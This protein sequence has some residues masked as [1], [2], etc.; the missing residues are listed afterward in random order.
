M[1]R[2]HYPVIAFVCIAISAVMVSTNVLGHGDVQPQPVDTTGLEP[3]GEWRTENPYSTDNNRAVEI[4][5]VGYTKNCARC[6]GLEAVSGGLAPD[7]RELQPGAEDDEWYIGIVREG[8]FQNGVPKMPPFEGILNQ[9]A[10]W[11]IRTWLETRPK[12]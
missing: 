3:L 11:A 9:E 6:H 10:M 1:M 4:G 7:L 12:E 2:K 5:Q 8:F